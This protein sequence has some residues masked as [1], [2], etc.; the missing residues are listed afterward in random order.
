M[1]EEIALRVAQRSSFAFE[2]TL[3]GLSYARAI[4]KWQAQ[5]YHIKLV[6]LTLLRVAARV[7]QGGHD[8]PAAVVQR[9]FAA[10]LRNF[11][12]QYKNR[13]NAWVLYDN[14]GDSPRVLESGENQ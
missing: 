13:V 11:H 4:P 5:G 12:Q 10:G 3:S 2:T 14:S 7:R 6:F 1:L 8:I 9:R